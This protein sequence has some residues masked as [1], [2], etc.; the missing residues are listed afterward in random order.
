MIMLMDKEYIE[1]VLPHRDPFL[2][3]DKVV[4]IEKKKIVAIKEVRDSDYFFKGHFPQYPVMPGVII[5]EALA[6]AGGVLLLRDKKGKVPLFLGIEKVRF[7]REVRPGDELRLEVEVIKERGEIVWLKGEAFVGD[8]LACKA[9]LLA[10]AFAR[11][12]VGK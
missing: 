8:E 4:K 9:E 6:Q 11:E 3:V 10:G 12:S 5:V 1:S 2:F 7:K